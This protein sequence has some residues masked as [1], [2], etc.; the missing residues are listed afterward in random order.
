MTRG[1]YDGARVLL[2]GHTGFKGQWL[3]RALSARSAKVYGFSLPYDIR[4]KYSLRTQVANVRPHFIFHLAAQAFV[5]RGYKDPLGTFEV[6]T[7]GTVN[8]LEAIRAE[9]IGPC[10]VVIVTTDKVYPAGD[11]AHR[12]D[13][14]LSGY[15]A[16][17]VSKHCPYAASKAAAEMA[18]AAYRASYFAPAGHRIAVATARAGNV[19]GG[20]D[21]GEGRLMPN[22]I[23]ALR[24]G[25]P[26]PVW[27]P[28]AT[29]P[30]QYV[31]DVID[32]YLKL[33]AALFEHQ[34]DF[35]EAWNF[36]PDHSRTVQ[37]V[38]EAI[39]RAWG[40]G[41]W[42]EQETTLR[43]VTSLHIDSTKART[44]LGW[45]PQVSFEKMIRQTV[46]WYWENP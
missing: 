16:S 4:G 6:N 13:D 26:I 20:G 14:P 35:A 8:L 30:W 9:V 43:E 34:G 19:L 10:A 15:D 18:V 3:M 5:P 2:T 27:N 29:R 39:V 31:T 1:V 22:A 7:L 11:R 33:G 44:R 42:A 46:R 24:E 36:G 21:W 38:A 17:D 28:Q 41:T 40:S 25:K 32:G 12:E 23:R 37:E 45:S